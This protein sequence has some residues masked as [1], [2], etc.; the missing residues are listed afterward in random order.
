MVGSRGFHVVILAPRISFTP[1][2]ALM[3]A[4]YLVAMAEYQ[5]SHSFADVLKAVENS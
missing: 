3:F 1:D 5:A 2:E 4:A